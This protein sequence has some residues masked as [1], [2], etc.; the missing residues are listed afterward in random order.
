MDFDQQYSQPYVTRKMNY[1][2]FLAGNSVDNLT[3]IDAQKKHPFNDDYT[4]EVEKTTKTADFKGGYQQND[5]FIHKIRVFFAQI[6]VWQGY[7][8][9]FV[10]VLSYWTKKNSG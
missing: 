9:I 1:K 3:V 7:S 8:N 4:L 10:G 5:I 6:L 2:D